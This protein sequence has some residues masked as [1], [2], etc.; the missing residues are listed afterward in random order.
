MDVGVVNKVEVGFRRYK[1]FLD[2]GHTGTM[3][4][5]VWDRRATSFRDAWR[6]YVEVF[7]AISA[8]ATQD[9]LEHYN[10]QEKQFEELSDQATVLK[11]KLAREA[12][13]L[14]E[15]QTTQK[16]FASLG[17]ELDSQKG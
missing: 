10:I 6:R 14:S 15:R 12:Q 17:I 11:E 13:E 9:Q 2:A 5:S 16:K 1:E 7:E 8:S 4:E 3:F